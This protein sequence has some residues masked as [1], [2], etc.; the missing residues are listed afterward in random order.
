MPIE[1]R[2]LV[3]RAVVDERRPTSAEPQAVN[4]RN[5]NGREALIQACVQQVMRI[6]RRERER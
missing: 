3:I 2:E 6:L 5:D 1:I 4:E